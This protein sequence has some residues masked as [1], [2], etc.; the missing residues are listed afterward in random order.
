M[1]VAF[2]ASEYNPFHNGH[3]YMIEK[4]KESGVDAVIA[5]MSG[6][7]VQRGEPACADKFLRAHAAVLGGADLVIELPV[8]FAV[9]TAS[10]FAKGFVDTAN[11][12][13]LDGIIS[14]GASSD[15]D[16]LLR[17]KEII[18][19]DKC[20]EYAENKISD[21]ISYPAAKQKYVEENFPDINCNILN[22]A[23][24]ILGLEYINA[25]ERS[26]S[27]LKLFSIKR[28]GVSHDADEPDGIFAS[29]GFIRRSIYENA[30]LNKIKQYVPTDVFNLF[31]EAMRNN[32]FPVDMKA[33]DIASFSR[34]ISF[35]ADYFRELNNVTGGIENRI[36]DAVRSSS[37]LT[38]VYDKIKSRHYTHSR[39]RQIILSSVLGIRKTD[40][41]CGVSYIRVLA[42]ND[43]GREVLHKMKASACIPVI[44][45][46]SQTIS[47]D[48]EVVRDAEL[49]Y[50]AG[51]F[52]NLCKVKTLSSN[53]EYDTHPV[54]IKNSST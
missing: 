27:S 37:C 36:T 38:E 8:K 14:F 43:K 19:S 15:I 34:L 40:L 51:K 21:G 49:D 52:Y 7:F 46:L 31:D 10:Y 39:V 1:R 35:S 50:N 17:I 20:Q 24:N 23:N 3:K 47:L 45:N 53:P 32:L 26:D 22:D 25:I 33:F 4:T 16:E 48:A 41:D 28:I 12:T 42:F 18:Y 6:N 30:D 2:I 54:Y 44:S 13:G 29:A 11:A 9:S 5:V